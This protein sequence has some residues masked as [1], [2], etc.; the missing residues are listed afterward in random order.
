MSEPISFPLAL[1]PPATAVSVVDD[2]L[3]D[4]A[5]AGSRNSPRLRVILPLH[6]QA[7]ALLQRM[8]NAI[9]PGSYIRPHRHG[10]ARGE[11]IVVLK[12]CL[13]YHEFNEDGSLKD[14]YTLSAGAG[15]DSDGGVWHSF[16]ALEADTVLFEVKPGPYNAGTDKEFA[17][18]APEEFSEEAAAYMVELQKATTSS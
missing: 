16:Q 5:L 1:D 9:Q 3:M 17:D 10:C 14:S 4:R 15:I 7:D 18:W 2:V 6:K 12:G 8:L 13:L 11:S